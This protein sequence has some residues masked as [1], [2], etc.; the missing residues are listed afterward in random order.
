LAA[1]DDKVPAGAAEELQE[2]ARRIRLA[3][4]G[5]LEHSA[6]MLA[7]HLTDWLIV[8]ACDAVSTTAAES[9]EPVSGKAQQRLLAWLLCDALGHTGAVL[10]AKAAEAAGKRLQRQALRVRAAVD[11]AQETA[12]AERLAVTARAVGDA[13]LTAWP[14]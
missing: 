12:G 3:T 1:G 9:T 13:A 5:E 10:D 7:E 14:M 2:R 11:A 4:G 8:L 6:D